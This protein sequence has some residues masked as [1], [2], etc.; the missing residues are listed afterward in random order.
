M[1]NLIYIS[2]MIFFICMFFT[3]DFILANNFFC[4][5]VVP[6]SLVPL[7][8]K[9]CSKNNFY[10][11]PKI[12]LSLSNPYSTLLLA[13]SWIFFFAILFGA[14]IVISSSLQPGWSS[15]WAFVLVGYLFLIAIFMLITARLA[16][17][18]E[19]Y[20]ERFF[21]FLTMLATI[22]AIINLHEYFFSLNILS[23][24]SE[25]R[26]FPTFGYIPDHHPTTSAMTYATCLVGASGLIIIQST[27]VRKFVIFICIIILYL[28]LCLT[29]SRGPIFGAVFSI[30]FSSWMAF[31]GLRVILLFLSSSAVGCF[32]VIPK[33][34]AGAIARFDNH[35]FEVW[36]RF[37]K[38][39]IERP[40]LGYGERI[41]FLVEIS[42][43]EKIGHAH[44]I[45]INSILRGGVFSFMALIVSY[46]M[47]VVKMS[48]FTQIFCNPIPLGL[49]V[50]VLI[51]G[52]FDFDQ[53]VFLADWQWV[54]FWLPLGLGVSIE[55]SLSKQGADLVTKLQE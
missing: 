17:Y 44:N 24:L 2:Y 41:E 45:F 25:L 32:L 13:K 14:V 16:L 38:L 31:R 48:Q 53:I 26:F 40:I 4:Y 37:I 6:L 18:Y 20:Y 1:I 39:V 36:W 47:C 43:G 27:I 21:T 7:D 34:G 28:A 10:S 8:F 30:T 55:R 15:G 46:A 51:S 19:H 5:F 50:L 29:Q 23:K 52:F 12:T 11:I 9:R 3:K 49:I 22:N 35:R 42:D 54:S 33:I